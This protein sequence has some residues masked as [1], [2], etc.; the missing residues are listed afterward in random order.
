MKD[1]LRSEA[2]EAVRLCRQAGIRTA[3]ITG[4]HKETAVAIA[5]ELGLQHN[6][7]LAL[8]GAELD[9]LTDEQLMQQIER[10]TV[11]ARVSAEHKLRVVQAWKRNGAIVAMTG[12]GV[13][14]A[15]AIK[16]SD[17]GVAMG[18]AGTDVTKEASDMVVTDDNFASI[19][20]AV[21]EGRYL[22]QHQEDGTFSFV[23]Q[24][25]RGA[26][27]AVCDPVRPAASAPADSHSVDEPR[28]GRFPSS[29]LGGRSESAGPDAAAPATGSGAFTG[30]RQA[31]DYRRRRSDVGGHCP[32]RLFV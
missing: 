14:D 23:V 30:W 16:A 5:R 3:M 8:S 15:P 19:A 27:H 22:R 6:D 24:Y 29:R 11:Y 21:E 2:T 7:D 10:V 28:D 25:E 26:R 9:G 1:P 17:I 4:D 31:V 12:D 32:G 20:A 18:L 13:N